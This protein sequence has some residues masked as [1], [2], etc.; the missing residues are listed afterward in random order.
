MKFAMSLIAVAG[1]AAAANAAQ[2]NLVWNVSVNGGAFSASANAN[3][4]DTLT[5]RLRVTLDTVGG[6][7][8]AIPVGGGLA[9]FNFLPTLAN[10]NPG[11]TALVLST[12]SFSTGSAGNPV[13]LTAIVH[14]DLGPINVYTGT[15][16]VTGRRGGGAF[17]GGIG[18]QGPFGA[19]GPNTSGVATSSVVANTLFWRSAVISNA[20]VSLSQLNAGNSNVIIPLLDDNLTPGDTTDDTV[21]F[22]GNGG[23]FANGGRTNLTVFTYSVVLGPDSAFRTLIGSSSTL[24]P[25]QWFTSAAG[26]SASHTGVSVTTTDASVN[27]VPAPGAL[28]LLGLGGLVAIRRRR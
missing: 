19:N 4:G 5:Y 17:G 16:P 1:I 7:G 2:T 28:A 25:V 12:E 24:T 10:F 9:G 14:P 18:R 22:A 21:N 15:L 20:G 13:P 27:V 8:A 6:T 11:D 3:P 26:A 23:S